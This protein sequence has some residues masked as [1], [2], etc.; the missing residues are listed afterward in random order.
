MIQPPE[1]A[2]PLLR[3]VHINPA[4]NRLS[5]RRERFDLACGAWQR[6]LFPASAAIWESLG[7]PWRVCFEQEMCRVALEPEQSVP[8]VFR[9]KYPP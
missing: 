6:Q 5:V 4:G 2:N 7:R 1:Q 3:H 8:I 9:T